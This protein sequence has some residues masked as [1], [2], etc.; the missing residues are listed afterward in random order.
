MFARQK[1]NKSGSVSVQVIA[2][3]ARKYIVVTTVGSSRDPDEI[4]RLWQRAQQLARSGD[5]AQQ[6]LLAIESN[7]DTAV[8][9]TM[10]SLAN[11]SI[12][13]VGPELIF[14][15]L[16]D[17]IG[18]NQI[19]DELFRHLIIA[20]LSFPLS[21][22]KTADY[23]NRYE[24]VKWSVSALYAFLDRLNKRYKAQAER[25]AY[26][27]TRKRLE[28]ITIVFYDMTTL[29]F[30]AEDED[31]LRKIGYSK[32]GKFQQPQIM[33][34]LLVGEAGLPIGYD[35]FTGNTFEG[36]TL[37]PILKQIQKKYGFDQPVVV[38]DAA[39]L[40]KENL[41]K[42][43]AAKYR[44]I[45]GARVKIETTAV[46]KE[47]LEKAEGIQ[48][49]EHFTIRKKDGTRLIVTYSDKRARKDARNREKGITR[50]EKR[51]QGGKLTKTSINN[52]GYNKFLVLDGEI[53]VA[54]DKEKV[55]EDEKWDGLKGY[56][57][58]TDLEA[59]SVVSNYG[60]LWQIEKAFRISKTDLR[61]RPIYHYK[62]S[63]IEAHICIAFVSYAIYKEL[64]MLLKKKGLAMSAKRAGELSQ[65][66]YEIQ[67]VLPQSGI[68]QKQLL[69]MTDEQ[70][71]LIDAV[72][73]QS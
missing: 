49:Q 45:I 66:M 65:N 60:H 5:P 34:G 2:K 11:S 43:G 54:I 10:Q 55:T 14:G 12:R 72:R 39:M 27:H 31:D 22:L 16:F 46:K 23:L 38:A 40:S 6:K 50:L 53:K 59:E 41:T 51:V 37:L 7:V 4:Q 28:T 30:E 24:G 3:Q 71:L 56:V 35:I 68:S 29:Y 52:R 48:N 32:D 73:V 70:Q 36:H 13:T 9:N 62:R 8:R 18:F 63:R 33:L 58:N 42:L 25:I 26:E 57:T 15:T 21:K 19:P 67:Y 17:R 69:Q 64:E 1:K 61:I 44:F 47:I 20:R